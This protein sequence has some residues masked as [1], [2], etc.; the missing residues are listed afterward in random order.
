MTNVLEGIGLA[1]APA[2]PDE[3]GVAPEETAP[4]AAP[5]TPAAPAPVETPPAE[6]EVVVPEGADRPDAVKAA[7]QN[8]RK[9]AREANARARD[10]ERQLR[11]RDEADKPLEERLSTAE[12][13]A[14]ESTLKAARLE[15]ALDKGLTVK[16]ASR[17]VG[18][19]KEELEA[20]ADEF[21]SELG[22]TPGT[23]ANIHLDGGY[24]KEPPKAKDPQVGHNNFLLG[25]MGR[26][27]HQQ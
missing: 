5:V 18:T 17:L 1:P 27:P 16:Q 14:T 15:V 8:E 13:R 22:S 25:A 3:A 24:K 4:P 2:V 9:N 21:V 23:P 7:I 26:Q 12:A 20:D 6:P 10:L 11:E 19:T